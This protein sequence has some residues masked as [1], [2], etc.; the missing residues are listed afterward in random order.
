LD[1]KEEGVI[2]WVLIAIF[3]ALLPLTGTYFVLIAYLGLKLSSLWAVMG[4]LQDVAPIVVGPFLILFLAWLASRIELL[5]VRMNSA[6]IGYLCV[7]AISLYLY[8]SISLL[9]LR[10]TNLL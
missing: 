10:S 4:L 9:Y 1:P 2:F 6:L 5:R 7:V 3:S 8:V